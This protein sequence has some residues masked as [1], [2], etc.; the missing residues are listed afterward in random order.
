MAVSKNNT[1]SDAATGVNLLNALQSAINSS[2]QR[3]AFGNADTEID[4]EGRKI[5]LPADPTKMSIDSAMAALERKKA[6]MAQ[7]YDCNEFVHGAPW[8][9]LVAVYRAM[10]DIYGWVSPESIKTFFGDILPD[11]VSVKTGLGD[12]DVLMIPVGKMVLPSGEGED[13]VEL[14]VNME[15]S[16]VRIRGKVRKADRARIAEIVSKAVDIIR[17]DSVYKAKAIK[18]NVD[19]DGEIVLT[20]QPEFIDIRDVKK[21]DVV[22]NRVEGDLIRVN[23]NSP[24]ENAHHC[25]RHKIPLKR[26]V[27]LH[28]PYGVGKSLTARVTAKIANDSGWTFIMLNRSLGLAS[29][30]MLARMYQPCVIFAEDVDRTADRSK[31]S[32]N[33]LV[34]ILDGVDTKNNEIMVVLTTNHIE[35]VDRS[36]LR[37]GR[38]DAVI[39]LSYPDRAAVESLVR[40]YAGSMLPPDADISE[41]C[42]IVAGTSPAAVREAVERAKFSAF[43]EGRTDSM[44]PDDLRIS[45]MGMKA[46]NDLM[47]TP[48]ESS[49]PKEKLWE[50][51]LTLVRAA[52]AGD[53][54]QDFMDT[55]VDI[56]KRVNGLREDLGGVAYTAKAAAAGAKKAAD[57]VDKI[58]A[59]R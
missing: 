26:G 21:D 5:I 20:S 24:L 49:G 23:I 37:P 25:R 3:G 38:F 17:H 10:Q 32:V 7:Q 19:D 31:E 40:K 12:K 30:L 43:G 51:M 48:V 8:D 16:G 47:K 46:H 9:A 50:G 11:F 29:A 58:L 36:L 27:L 34:N 45:A 2:V 13:K 4:Y 14:Y 57:G 59:S 35:L 44:T 56:S 39:G 6:E 33:D 52:H 54:N 15:G 22:Y 1:K 55:M 28:G 18:L 42:E 41:V 53:D